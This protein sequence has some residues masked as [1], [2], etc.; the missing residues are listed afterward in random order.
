M[1][2]FV[3]C[4]DLSSLL[5]KS[6]RLSPFCVSTSCLPRIRSFAE[7]GGLGSCSKMLRHTEDAYGVLKRPAVPWWAVRAAWQHRILNDDAHS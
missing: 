3:N 5:T 2:C 1:F 4:E 7:A 6:D